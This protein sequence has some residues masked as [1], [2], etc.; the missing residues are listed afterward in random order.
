MSADQT[1]K[2]KL[3]DA[4]IA[5]IAFGIIAGCLG[6]G[7]LLLLDRVRPVG[8]VVLDAMF[9]GWMAFAARGAGWRR[10]ALTGGVVFASL[11]SLE[12][13]IFS[14]DWRRAGFAA[15]LGLLCVGVALMMSEAWRPWRLPVVSTVVLA[16]AG[17]LTATH[18]RTAAVGVLLLLAALGVA[19]YLVLGRWVRRHVRGR[20]AAAA[21]ALVAAV[22]LPVGVLAYIANDVRHGGSYA[23]R[24]GD[25]VSV[26]IGGRC[27]VM[28]RTENG[29]PVKSLGGSCNGTWWV[30]GEFRTGTIGGPWDDMVPNKED[31]PAYALGDRAFLPSA[32]QDD[33]LTLLGHLVPLWP[34]AGLP[35]GVIAAFSVLITSTL[36]RRPVHSGPDR[37]H[38][39]IVVS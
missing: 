29:I 17:L 11:V 13:A 38:G 10:I 6:G 35:L 16:S 25:A 30:N 4:L 12:L 28:K 27:V 18:V 32:S 26:D 24:Y 23:R 36:I 15:L 39:Q 33:G 31:Q 7:F 8:A 20:R 19:I 37:D 2:P 14:P 21:S 1:A 9:A 22:L 5:L 3:P 34:I